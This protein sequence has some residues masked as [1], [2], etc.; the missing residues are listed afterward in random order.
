MAMGGKKTAAMPPEQRPNLF[1]IRLRDWERRNLGGGKKAESAFAMRARQFLK[2]RPDLEQK[3]QP[4]GLSLVTAFA[5]QAGQMQVRRTQGNAN[6]LPGFAAAAG[7]GRLARGH[8]KLAAA[9]APEAAVGLLR[10]PHQ[11]HFIR[12][13]EAVEQRG[14]FVGQRHANQRNIRFQRENTP[15]PGPWKE[16]AGG[17]GPSSA[18]TEK[19]EKANTT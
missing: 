13:I 9:R 7:K 14:D 18:I 15:K 16:N 6:F 17:A 3:H 1:G 11:E 2:A 8:F 10:A 19:T 5:D 4:M 12:A